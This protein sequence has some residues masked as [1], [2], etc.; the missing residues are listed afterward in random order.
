MSN[1]ILK[2]KK[3]D[4]TLMKNLQVSPLLAKIFVNRNI[5]TEKNIKMIL[6]SDINDL[7]DEKL[8]PDIEKATEFIKNKI[9]EKK[10]IRIVGDYDIDGVSSTYILYDAFS[11]LGANVSFVIPNR[12]TDGYGINIKIIEDC[13]KDKVDTIITCDNGISADKEITFA[14]QHGIEVVV[15]DHHD[16]SSIPKDA[17][18]VVDPKRVDVENRYPFTGICGAVVAWKFVKYLF[19]KFNEEFKRAPQAFARTSDIVDIVDEDHDLINLDYKNYLDFA[20]L[21]TVGDI[22]PLIDENHII[23]K[24]GLN[25]IKETKN[26]GLKKLIE[27]ADLAGRDINV[28]AL[29]FIIG[30]MINASGR[31]KTADLAL[32]LFLTN[33]DKRINELSEQLKSLNDER[34]N[35]TNEGEEKALDLVSEFYKNDKVLVIYV[36]NIS[37]SIAG[38]VAGRVKE[39][40]NKPTIILTDSADENVCKASARSIEEYDMFSN[41]HKH[42]E[43][44]EKFGGH[45]LA[46]G[47]SIKKEKID[48]LRK[49][50][51]EECDLEEKDFIK[52]VYVDIELPFKYL[53]FNILSDISSLE[54]FGNGFEKPVL[55]LTNVGYKI[56][57]IYGSNRNVVRLVL[58]KDGIYMPA[59][60][61]GDGDEFVNS[62]KNAE[63]IS[64]LYY[65]IINDFNNKQTIEIN[66]KEYKPK[67]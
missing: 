56:S 48:E 58:N 8:L 61:F 40:Y 6:S 55:G 32:E 46:A 12:V 7:N 20:A 60:Y 67:S 29:G 28:F 23:V 21:A 3:V 16:V 39:K 36:E 14:K 24:L 66:I 64:I 62:L 2:S 4:K 13:I 19:F 45:K 59:V 27:I 30:P 51:N 44:F 57:N 53:N 38:I 63:N 43:K 5:D 33:D 17:Y 18:A 49:V 15:T 31:L 52:K 42:I 35:A 25:A 41:L 1:W 9:I 54:P 65:P 22:M 26:K 50:L 37:E 11:K 47:F 10:H 34:K